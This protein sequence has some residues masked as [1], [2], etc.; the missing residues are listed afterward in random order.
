MNDHLSGTPLKQLASALLAASVRLPGKLFANG[1]PELENPPPSLQ[2]PQRQT[3]PN[4]V[5]TFS[6]R[7]AR[8]GNKYVLEDSSA[9]VS[10]FLDDQK[11][12]R[13]FDGQRVTITGTL[14]KQSNVL[15]VEKIAAS[16]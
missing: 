15:H 8:A 13:K 10:Y 16:A 11:S 6:G 9:K 7:I 12:A 3:S 4:E 5:R 2:T 14:D 1:S